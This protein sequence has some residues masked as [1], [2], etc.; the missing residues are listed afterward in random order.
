MA[1]SIEQGMAGERE[2][3]IAGAVHTLRVD[4]DGV[5]L[6]RKGTGDWR[7]TE[8]TA[9]LNVALA[10]TMADGTPAAPRALRVRAAR[11]VG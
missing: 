4:A 8:W 3:T 5:W 9:V 7:L 10:R 6:K 11:R 2:V 1:L